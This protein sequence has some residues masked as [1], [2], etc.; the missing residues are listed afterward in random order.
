MF[1][2]WRF[3]FLLF[4]LFFCFL[5]LS[6]RVLHLSYFNQNYYGN[7]INNARATKT[8]KKAIRGKI[9]DCN[10]SILAITTVKIDIG[11]DPYVIDEQKDREKI[12]Q[13]AILLEKKS[14]DIAIFFKRESLIRDGKEQRVRWKKI[15]TI[16]DENLYREIKDLQIK[17]IYGNMRNERVYPNNELA[18]HIIGF[19]NREGVAI[20][21]V[22]RFLNNF[23][24][25]KDGW[26]VSEKNGKREEIALFR[27]SVVEP[28]NGFDVTLTIELPV[29]TI[30]EQAL[31]RAMEGLG[32]KNGTVIVSDPHTGAIL[33]LCNVPTFNCNGY[34]QSEVDSLRNR[35][36]TDTYEPGS[37][38]KIVPFSIALQRKLIS[39]DQCFDCS[40][41]TFSYGDRHYSLPHDHTFFGKLSAMDV[42]RKSS[43]R[44][45]AQIGIILGAEQLYQAARAF[46][47]GEKTGYGFDGEAAGFL[48][49]PK[50]WDSLTITRLPIGHA[51]SATPL[52]VHQAM[53]VIASGGY[54]LRPKI[55]SRILDDQE[56]VTVETEPRIIRQVLAPD[57]A[58]KLGEV[59]HN[60]K[61]SSSI[62]VG[63]KLAYKTGTSQKLINGT[64]SREHHVASC[65]GFFPL[66]SPQFLITVVLDDPTMPSGGTAYG[67]RA[68]YPVFAEIAQQ[69]IAFKGLR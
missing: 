39:L 66:E 24:C 16:D 32:A 25:G 64:Y 37:I 1:S 55:I 11:V 33:A 23:L 22:E 3:L 42:L 27:T 15:V 7:F 68:A 19:V 28:R 21:G 62:I 8:V 31:Q 35:A 38:F 65:S 50:L 48:P 58:K 5:G 30:A 53:G 51:I 17:G 40:F 12:A 43:N 49:R 14:E 60:P 4:V 9:L 20:S 52:Q 61:S 36:V 45:L 2:R 6:Y 47:F 59:L 34:A 63:I 69:L 18:S 46:G 44:G 67:I 41:E 13:L 56:E 57:I 29:Q 10:G 54:L 26:I